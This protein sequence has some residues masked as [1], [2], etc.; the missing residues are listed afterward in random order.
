MTDMPDDVPYLRVRAANETGRKLLRQMRDGGAPVLT[1]A[2]DVSALGEAAE[3][4]FTAEAGRTDLYA[5][6]RPDLG[7]STCG[8]DWRASPI[9]L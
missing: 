7:Q 8:S 9:M 2:A 6:S 3:Q 1:K 5:L 4:L